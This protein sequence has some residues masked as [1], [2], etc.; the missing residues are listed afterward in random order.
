MSARRALKFAGIWSAALA[1]AVAIA[2]T[3]RP[4][5]RHAV[6]ALL[7][8][9]TNLPALAGAANVHY[10]PR[11]LACAQAVADLAPR[12][13]AQI[14][15]VHGRPFAQ[16]PTVGVYASHENYGS[17]NGMGDPG[18]AAVT[19]AGAALL[20]PTLC[21][22]E[23]D[24]LEGVLAHELSHVHLSGWRPLGAPRPPQ[25]FTEGLAVMA[26]N[27]GGAEGVSIE[28]AAQAIRDGYRVVLDER[29]W[30]DFAGLGFE[31]EP[32]R[33]PTKDALTQRQRLAYL[34]AGMFVGWL[35]MRD[36]NAFTQLLRA[37]E[38]G[39]PFGPSFE[40]AF[41]ENAP[42]LWLRFVSTFRRNDADG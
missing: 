7:N 42:Q 16:P 5:L 1:V 32:P 33:D 19:R 26:S 30:I 10:E 3:I 12:A 36:Q 21:G 39:R 4:P 9:P 15:S 20:S 13:I 29:P 6:A 23:R 31:R 27:G 40:S 22:Q 34:Q 35:R 24:R 2:F 14:E 28:D 11:A 17:A 18:I 25:W 8:D 38:A 37:L 41:G